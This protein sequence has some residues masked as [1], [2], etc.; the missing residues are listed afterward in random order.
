MRTATVDDPQMWWAGLTDTGW[1][2]VRGEIRNNGRLDITP[3]DRQRLGRAYVGRLIQIAECRVDGKTVLVLNCNMVPPFGPDDWRFLPE[4][5]QAKFDGAPVIVWLKD[6]EGYVR[7]D[8]SWC[9]RNETEQTAAFAGAAVIYACWNLYD[10]PRTRIES[11][12]RTV[13]AE[14]RCVNKRWQVTLVG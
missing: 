14:A 3:E 4:A 6:A 7:V 12:E 9:N 10:N 5:L 8:D 13:E 2:I 11:A 1:Q